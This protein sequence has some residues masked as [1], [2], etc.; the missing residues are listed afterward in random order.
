MTGE[1][2]PP[3]IARLKIVLRPELDRTILVISFGLIV[4]LIG[5]LKAP[6]TTAGIFPSFRARRASFFPREARTS[7][8]TVIS[9][10][11]TGSFYGIEVRTVSKSLRSTWVRAPV[12]LIGHECTRI[13]TNENQN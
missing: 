5:S 1:V 10:L 4:M 13:N 11:K 7:A 3:A 2:S 8:V 6:Y 9:F 12:F